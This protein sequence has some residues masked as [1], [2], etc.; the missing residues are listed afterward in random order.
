MLRA[1]W[2]VRTRE[3]LGQEIQLIVR[4]WLEHYPLIGFCAAVVWAVYVKQPE[5][6][7]N[8]KSTKAR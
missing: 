2:H 4:R 6:S 8:P 3:V 1:V 7:P 5:Q